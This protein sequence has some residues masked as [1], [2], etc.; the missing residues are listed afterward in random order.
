MSI[1][2]SSLQTAQHLPARRTDGPGPVAREIWTC[3]VAQRPAAGIA[4]GGRRTLGRLDRVP[5]GSHPYPLTAQDMSSRS[6]TSAAV[7]DEDLDDGAARLDNNPHFNNKHL[8][9]M[10][11]QPNGLGASEATW[12]TVVV[13]PG[14]R[15]VQSQNNGPT[16]RA[17]RRSCQNTSPEKR[18]DSGAVP[19]CGTAGSSGWLA[20]Y[21]DDR[22]SSIDVTFVRRAW[23]QGR[24]VHTK[25]GSTGAVRAASGER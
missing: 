24:D 11:Q 19:A 9:I 8:Q 12:I 22:R 7:A 25:L 4:I 1:S 13:D 21:V 14:P 3:C 17:D 10:D 6:K 5:P 18:C 16:T 23:T 20:A 2:S 15:A